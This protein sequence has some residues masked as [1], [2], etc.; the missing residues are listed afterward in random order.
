MKKSFRRSFIKLFNKKAKNEESELPNI[1]NLAVFDENPSDDV[2][3]V[4][5]TSPPK[6]PV[7][8]PLLQCKRQNRFLSNDQSFLDLDF[9]NVRVTKSSSENLNKDISET[10]EQPPTVMLSPE[11]RRS[12]KYLKQ[13]EKLNLNLNSEQNNHNIPIN[14][15]SRTPI[16]QSHTPPNSD[17]FISS[18]S[19]KIVAHTPK[20]KRTFAG[21][22]A[23]AQVA[24][25]EVVRRP[26]LNS[27]VVQLPVNSQNSQTRRSLR[28]RMRK[29]FRI[30]LTQELAEMDAVLKQFEQPRARKPL[31]MPN[32]AETIPNIPKKDVICNSQKFQSLPR[33]PVYQNGMEDGEITSQYVINQQRKRSNTL[34][35]KSKARYAEHIAELNSKITPNYLYEG[36]SIQRNRSHTLSGLI[37]NK[38]IFK[39]NR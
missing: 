27:E 34:A 19:G 32:I 2:I 9:G 30:S 16:N 31:H 17:A 5:I 25:C 21:Q 6:P 26:R 35:M 20:V 29:S 14:Q 8:P 1:Q 10:R 24:K 13:K 33:A 28:R 36:N 15:V 37:S 12:L 39:Q 23:A 18:E 7:T 22:I 38:A 3:N 11:V 4:N